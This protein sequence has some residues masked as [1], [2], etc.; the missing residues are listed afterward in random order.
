MYD[1]YRNTKLLHTWG[2]VYSTVKKTKYTFTQY[3]NYEIF[4]S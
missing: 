2:I 1:E 3:I 4:G